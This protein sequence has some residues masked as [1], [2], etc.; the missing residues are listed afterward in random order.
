MGQKLS[1]T[2]ATGGIQDSQEGLDFQWKSL[3]FFAA[4]CFVLQEQVKSFAVLTEI[5]EAEK[6][7]DVVLEYTD[8]HNDVK[9]ILAQAKHRRSAKLVDSNSLIAEDNFSLVK[10]FASFWEIA[11][12]FGAQEIESVMIITNNTLAGSNKILKV[13]QVLEMKISQ[14]SESL[15]L[16]K[17]DHFIFGSIGEIYRFVDQNSDKRD[18]LFEIVRIIILSFELASLCIKKPKTNFLSQNQKYLFDTIIDQDSLTIKQ[19]FVD[20]TLMGFE[21]FSKT[22]G[23]ALKV[24]GEKS[25]ANFTIPDIIVRI[26]NH[27]Q[28]IFDKTVDKSTLMD[29]QIKS[30][31]AIDQFLD[32]LS[33]VTNLKTKDLHTEINSQFGEIF[34]RSGIDDISN[35]VELRLRTWLMDRKNTELT[36]SKFEDFIIEA[37]KDLEL[38]IEKDKLFRD[39]WDFKSILSE[40]RN[41]LN[42]INQ[43]QPRILRLET[44]EGESHFAAMRIVSNYSDPLLYLKA[45][46]TDEEFKQILTFFEKL[47]CYKL[48]VV[49]LQRESY[50]VFKNRENDL[51]KILQ[52]GPSKKL[53][54][55]GDASLKVNF[56]NIQ[57]LKEDESLFTDLVV[58]LQDQILNKNIRFQDQETTWRAVLDGHDFDKI[59]LKDVIKSPQLG[60]KIKISKSYGEKIYIDRTILYNNSLKSSILQRNDERINDVF[61]FDKDEFEKQRQ[62]QVPHHLL[63]RPNNQLEW[64]ESSRDLSIILKNVLESNPKKSSEEE[65]SKFPAHV[66]IISDIAGMGKSSLFC[67]LAQALKKNN[68]HHWIFNL[69]LDNHSAALDKLTKTKLYNPNDAVDF[70]AEKIMKLESIFEKKH[71]VR[72][73]TETGKVIFLIDGVDEIFSSYG[74]EVVEL[75]KL[76]AQTKIKKI[77]MSTRPECCERLEKEFLQIKHSLEP[78][79]E[80]DQKKYFLEFLKNNDKLKDLTEAELIEI[81]EAFLESIKRSISAKDY[82][83]TGV[84]LITKLVAKYLEG[85]IS[86]ANA[87]LNE[88]VESLKA[89]VFHLLGLYEDFITKSFDIYFKDKS[90]MDVKKAI[91]K[92]RCNEEKR[93]ILENYKIFAIQQILKK[94]AAQ[95]FPEFANKKFTDFEMEEMVTVGLIHKTEVGYKFVHQTF[96]EYLFT[97]HLMGN[98]EQPEVTDFIVHTVFVDDQFQVIRSFVEFC[99]EEETTPANFDIYFEVFLSEGPK[100]KHTTP[101]HISSKEQNFKTLNFIYN[102]LTKSSGFENK[103]SK[104][105]DYF[106][107]CDDDKVPAIFELIRWSEN[108]NQFLDS[109]KN[110]FRSEFVLSIFHY[111]FDSSFNNHENLLLY[112][113]RNGHNLPGLLT[114][115]RLNFDDLYFLEN[116][117]FKISGFTIDR[118]IVYSIFN[119]AKFYNCGL[120]HYSFRFLSKETLSSLLDEIKSWE[121]VLGKG[122]IQKLLLMEDG[123]YDSFLIYYAQN[124]NFNTDFLIQVLNEIKIY[125]ENDES[126]LS[127]IV[128]HRFR[129]DG[130]LNRMILN[131]KSS[132]KIIFPRNFC[133]FNN[134]SRTFLDYFCENSKNFDLLKFLKWLDDSFGSEQLKILLETNA[135]NKNL[136]ILRYFSND[137]NLIASGLE[138]LKYLKE[139]KFDENFLK[140]RIILRESHWN[141]NVL[142]QIFLRSE[143][144]D[145]F[146]DF[147]ENQFKISDSEL[148]ALIGT[149][150]T[151]DSEAIVGIRGHL[152]SIFIEMLL[153][154][155]RWLLDVVSEELGIVRLSPVLLFFHIAQKS[156]E[157]QEKY[158]NFLKNKFGSNILKELVSNESLFDICFQSDRSDDFGTNFLKFFDF[159]KRKFGIDLLIKLFC[160]KALND[161]TFLF[162]LYKAADRGLIKIL[163]YSFHIL[164]IKNSEKFLLSVDLK[165]N[166]FLI[167]FFLQSNVSRTTKISKE[168]FESIKF[169]FGL[170]FLKKLLLLKN[171]GQNFYRALLENKYGGPEKCL[172]VLESLLEVV[173]KDKEFFIELTKQNDVFPEEIKEFLGK[174][175]EIEPG[176]VRFTFWENCKQKIRLYRFFIIFMFLMVL[177]FAITD[178]TIFRLLAFSVI[179]C[180]IYDFINC[181]ILY[182]RFF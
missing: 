98:F 2:V 123:D 144:L 64:I 157:D 12:K 94:D 50:H 36:K 154:Y 93:K 122:S 8:Q 13:G 21:F 159:V 1:K 135:S 176:D 55:T 6:F 118:E 151:Y 45:N 182:C 148:T 17:T 117:I 162:P 152:K 140:N 40:T 53:V 125:F 110:D 99:I 31:N 141:D 85:K 131:F 104:I 120:L 28:N 156:E 32:K 57:T 153:K 180:I 79:S 88:V 81:V 172:E 75:V 92:R 76:L 48:M 163:K 19:D 89:E 73:C 10:Y 23:Q 22:F 16:E 129:I 101:I 34:K 107:V 74:E 100:R 178:I 39:I 25:F 142:K 126:F 66:T 109:V 82:R 115:M 124:D 167:H 114:W 116:Q 37:A 136:F 70:V 155:V 68:P 51:E 30:D 132:R 61:N 15:Y 169:S 112:I 69:E 150:V 160:C 35:K 84:P 46:F 139:M 181:Y 96:A 108:L 173:G 56:K 60:N 145:Q 171:E 90:G 91:N 52:N 3:T 138:I 38:I 80:S 14:S 174:M 58:D 86:Y 54:I 33:Y 128:F 43:S 78:F 97:L 146:M 41:F 134:W 127:K 113:S 18:K 44:S 9:Y 143:S 165:G 175:L 164:K 77:F 95:F 26:Q 65:F 63:F 137:H 105:E 170:G 59:L 72:S 103:K 4:R 121:P 11:Q 71:F 133:N 24:A 130:I 47:S 161:R 62:S 168:L 179:Y 67:K 119:F 27:F 29:N 106:F 102:C 166:N 49:E 147:I 111:E 5:K 7:D 83:H 158:L 87:T 149:K 42:T 20:E 177:I